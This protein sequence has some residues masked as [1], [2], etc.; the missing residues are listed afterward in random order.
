MLVDE[1]WIAV[2][3]EQ[4]QACGSG[5]R[6]APGLLLIDGHK[7]MRPGWTRSVLGPSPT[8]AVQVGRTRD[9]RDL[10]EK[11]ALHFCDRDG[12]PESRR[13]S[14]TEAIEQSCL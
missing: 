12:E 2:R 5:R 6:L 8:S 7:G 4:N 14:E 9:S 1:D 11:L 3:V 13:E 10:A